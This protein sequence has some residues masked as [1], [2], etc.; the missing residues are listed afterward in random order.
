MSPNIAFTNDLLLF[1]H[2]APKDHIINSFQVL[3][4]RLNLLRYIVHPFLINPPA[5]RTDL[6]ELPCEILSVRVL[7][8]GKVLADKF[9]V[10]SVRYNCPVWIIGKNVKVPF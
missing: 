5:F 7:S 1:V 10:A 6:N 2:P 8:T 4:F 3:C 9:W